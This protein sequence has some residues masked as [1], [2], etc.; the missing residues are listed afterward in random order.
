MESSPFLKIRVCTLSA[1]SAP[2]R[3]HAKQCALLP[4]PWDVYQ[5]MLAWL[6]HIET[7]EG[8]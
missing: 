3:L 2:I 4:S 5:N 1:H 7:L 8:R 6:H